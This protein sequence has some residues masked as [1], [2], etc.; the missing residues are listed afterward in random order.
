MILEACEYTNDLGDNISVDELSKI[1]LKMKSIP[2]DK[3]YFVANLKNIT[4]KA[5]LEI[6]K[7]DKEKAGIVDA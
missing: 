6:I 4:L 2:N 5:W 7:T 3:P 1:S